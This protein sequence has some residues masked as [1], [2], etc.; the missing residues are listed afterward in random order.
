MPENVA[1]PEFVTEHGVFPYR[2]FVE[3][4]NNL[5]R[6]YFYIKFADFVQRWRF[7]IPIKLSFFVPVGDVRTG[8]LLLSA[9]RKKQIGAFLLDHNQ[10]YIAQPFIMT[11]FP[12]EESFGPNELRRGSRWA[13]RI[14]LDSG[15]IEMGV[16]R[17]P[18]FVEYFVDGGSFYRGRITLRLLDRT[19]IG[20][21]L[22]KIDVVVARDSEKI[23]WVNV[24]AEQ[25]P[26]MLIRG[27]NKSLK[28]P[29]GFSAI[30]SYVRD[31]LPGELR[32]W[33]GKGSLEQT[34]RWVAKN[35]S[36]PIRVSRFELIN[37]IPK[38][39]SEKQKVTV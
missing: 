27:D 14:L 15:M 31:L 7:F 17:T 34:S 11:R 22:E 38:L 13:Y 6:L 26:I 4:D 28:Q 23:W 1:L 20:R 29:D 2:F 16:Q 5:M 3:F 21:F 25:R 12:E 9:A 32:W 36:F 30:P 33:E 19:E 35:L 24:T 37:P 10:R 39:V 8:Q 18:D